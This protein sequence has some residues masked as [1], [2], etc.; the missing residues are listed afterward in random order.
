MAQVDTRPTV[1][2]RRAD[3]RFAP[4]HHVAVT[5]DFPHPQQPFQSVHGYLVDLCTGGACVALE[6][7]INVGAVSRFTIVTSDTEPPLCLV[8]RVRH[9]TPLVACYEYAVGLDIAP[10]CI[11]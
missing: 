9:C 8:A 1:H 4:L 3:P 11:A 6:R 10:D 5:L 7:P 2:Q